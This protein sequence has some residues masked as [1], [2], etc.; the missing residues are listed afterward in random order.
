MTYEYLDKTIKIGDRTAGNR[1]VMPPMQTDRTHMGR[2]TEDMIK[3]YKDRAVYSRPGVI[4]TE[5]CYITKD[6][7][8]SDQLSIA[9]DGVIE[10]HYRIA[11]AIH[12]GG[13]L[14][15]CQI[16]HAGSKTI[17]APVSASD[18]K[19]PGSPEGPDPRPLET[20]EIKEIEDLFAAAAVRVK[21]AGYDGV[22]LHCAHSY[23]LNQFW[24]PLT[25]KRTD[26]Y[27]GSIENRLRF[28]TETITKVRAAVGEEM[29]LAVRLGGC[30]YMDGG[31]TEEDAL[32]AAKIIEKAGVDLIDVSGGMCRFMIAGHDE[33]G[34]FRGTSEKVRAVV[35]VPVILTGGVKTLEDAEKLL[36]EGAA[37]MIGVG[38]ALYKDPAWGKRL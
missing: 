34:F 23:L 2:A 27:G 4:I 28:L 25:N 14:A 11:D 5:H 3:Y 24:S 6:G 10:D 17:A 8:V 31:N 37:D 9:D 30:D 22:E 18:V 13:A 19:T 16:N 12:D 35:S 33:P 32:E 21:K 7:R 20:E 15:I 36:K 26:E 38:R 1:L 29:I